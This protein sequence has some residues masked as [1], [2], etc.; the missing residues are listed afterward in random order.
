MKEALW[1]LSK[2]RQQFEVGALELL[3][4]EHD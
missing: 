1:G 3:A 2:Y 4:D